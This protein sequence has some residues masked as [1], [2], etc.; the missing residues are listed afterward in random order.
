M[1]PLSRTVVHVGPGG[2]PGQ[3]LPLPRSLPRG[4]GGSS[5]TASLSD[6]V[7]SG[8]FWSFHCSMFLPHQI[9]RSLL[10][11]RFLFCVVEVKCT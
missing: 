4:Q 8:T 6:C 10:V 1:T 3:V 5:H 9:N 2:C 11:S 7:H